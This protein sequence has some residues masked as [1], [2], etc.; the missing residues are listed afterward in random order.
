MVTPAGRLTEYLTKL[1]PILTPTQVIISLIIHNGIIEN[2]QTLKT[3]LK[4]MG[5]SFISDTDSE[6]IAHLI[7]S[8]LKKGNTILASQSD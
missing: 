5:Y 2:Y 7:D 4:N 6:V 1:M 3:S 8:F